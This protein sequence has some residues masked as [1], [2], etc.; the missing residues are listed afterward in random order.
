MGTT[1]RLLPGSLI[2]C[3]LD[4]ITQDVSLHIP[5]S[6]SVVMSIRGIMDRVRYPAIERYNLKIR[7]VDYFICDCLIWSYT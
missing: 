4:S 3:N 1:D 6:G 7:D 2:V 5:L